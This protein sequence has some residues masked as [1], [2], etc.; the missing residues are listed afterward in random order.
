[1]NSVLP[2]TQLLPELRIL[3]LWFLL[4]L[5]IGR[6]QGDAP[7]IPLLALCMVLLSS[8]SLLPLGLCKRHCKARGVTPWQGVG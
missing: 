1:M 3:L 4:L 7:A 2:L 6:W 8:S 5:D